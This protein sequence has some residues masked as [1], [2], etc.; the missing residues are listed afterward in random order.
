MSYTID[1]NGNYVFDRGSLGF[2]TVTPAQ[3]QQWLQGWVKWQGLSPNDPNAPQI[4]VNQQPQPLT[5]GGI[6]IPNSSCTFKNPA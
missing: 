3:Y 4:L 5:S 6:A 2:A 1:A